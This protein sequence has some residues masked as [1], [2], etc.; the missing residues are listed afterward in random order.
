MVSKTLPKLLKTFST[1]SQPENEDVQNITQ[2]VES[3]ENRKNKRAIV[4]ENFYPMNPTISTGLGL[5]LCY[6]SPLVHNLAIR[7]PL[8]N[9]CAKVLDSFD[10]PY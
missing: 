4:V 9:R 10:S 7:I 6:I 2:I 5:S 8:P 1:V 3:V